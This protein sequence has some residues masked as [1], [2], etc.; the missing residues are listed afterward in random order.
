[1]QLAAAVTFVERIPRLL[2]REDEDV[3]AAVAGILVGESI[4][5]LLEL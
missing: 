3:T 2:P 1:M 5:A 4:A